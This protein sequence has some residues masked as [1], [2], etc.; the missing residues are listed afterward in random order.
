MMRQVGTDNTYSANNAVDR[1][2]TTLFHTHNI[3]DPWWRVD[4]QRLHR[5]VA[6]GLM[7]RGRK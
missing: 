5:V 6:V 3:T 4:L 7:N 2:L 1:N